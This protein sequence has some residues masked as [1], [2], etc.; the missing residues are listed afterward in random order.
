MQ[1]RYFSWPSLRCPSISSSVFCSSSFLPSTLLIFFHFPR[2]SFIYHFLCNPC[3]SG[4]LSTFP[5]NPITVS[6][7]HVLIS[8]SCTST[9]PISHPIPNS[10]LLQNFPPSALHH[11]NSPH[12]TLVFPFGTA[13]FSSIK[14]TFLH[15]VN[16]CHSN[17][18]P[19][20]ASSLSLY[21]YTLSHFKHLCSPNFVDIDLLVH[22]MCTDFTQNTLTMTKHAPLTLHLIIYRVV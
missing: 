7:T 10:Y 13:G 9:F 2:L 14:C 22:S 3:P 17:Y 21:L 4:I 12:S 1:S 11:I 8:V 16:C 18:P 19:H 20:T 15:P 6:N 5:T